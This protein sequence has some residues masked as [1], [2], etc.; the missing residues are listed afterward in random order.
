M[1]RRF[2]T[3]LSQD[4][5]KELSKTVP[6]WELKQ[7]RPAITKTFNFADFNQAWEFM[8]LVAKVAEERNHH[9][10]WFNVY[11]RVDVTLSTHDAGGITQKDFWLASFMDKAESLIKHNLDD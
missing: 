6:T 10:E 8:S 9:P 4:K 7:D 1:L 2:A 5:L 3:A 11:N